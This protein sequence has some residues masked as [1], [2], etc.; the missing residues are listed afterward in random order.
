MLL[1]A[2]EDGPVEVYT[3]ALPGCLRYPSLYQM[4]GLTIEEGSGRTVRLA[5]YRE[6]PNFGGGNPQNAPR[7][8][9]G[10]VR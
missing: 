9:P 6:R 10:D 3:D 8:D 4:A 5:R 7:S 1:A 2:C